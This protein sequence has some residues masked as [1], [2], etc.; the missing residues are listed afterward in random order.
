MKPNELFVGAIVCAESPSG[1]CEVK[2]ILSDCW[3]DTKN[4]RHD[5]ERTESIH[6]TPK[7]LK[8]IGFEQDGDEFYLDIKRQWYIHFWN[9]KLTVWE[10]CSTYKYEDSKTVFEH[11]VISLDDVQ[12]LFY[13]L[14]IDKEI[15][16]S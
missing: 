2:E 13:V 8:K 14:G 7:I 12:R 16:L 15:V 5:Y 3:I 4:I 9:F 10:D 11:T 1:I 6:L